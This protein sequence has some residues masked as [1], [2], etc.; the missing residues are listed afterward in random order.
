MWEKPEDLEIVRET[1]SASEALLIEGLL[2][3]AGVD[4]IVMQVADSTISF[5]QLSVFGDTAKPMPY[6]ILVRPEDLE[7][8][9]ELLENQCVEANQDDE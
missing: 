3:S 8:A 2:K 1:D 7:A 6:K 4:V 5:V 9:K